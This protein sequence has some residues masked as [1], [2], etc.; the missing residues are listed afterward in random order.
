MTNSGG[1]TTISGGSVTTSGDI[2]VSAFLRPA[3]VRALRPTSNGTTISTGNVELGTG[4]NANGVQ[5]DTGG[6][7]DIERRLGGRD[8]HGLFGPLRHRDRI[9][10]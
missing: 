5:A 1:A 8:R 6:T 7:V 2:R 10:N 9:D 3:Q 4:A